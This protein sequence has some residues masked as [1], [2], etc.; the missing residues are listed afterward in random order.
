MRRPPRSTHLPYT[1]LFR[2]AARVLP[3]I[4]ASPELD[5]VR[6]PAAVQRDDPGP[7]L[8]R[9]VAVVDLR[10]GPAEL[11]AVRREARDRKRTRLNSS[12]SNLSYAV[13][14]LKKIHIL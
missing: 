4:V 9:P 10:A 7:V 12:H 5:D 14:C 11:R 13:F 3:G 8:N 1:T 2:S 6:R